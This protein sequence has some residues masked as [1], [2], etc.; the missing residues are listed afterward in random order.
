VCDVYVSASGYLVDGRMN[1]PVGVER[2]FFIKAA[3]VM[4]DS[5]DIYY[6]VKSD[7]KERR[8]PHAIGLY[9]I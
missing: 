3:N 6:Q 4:L 8:K 7:H 1:M 2:R 9:T 5:D